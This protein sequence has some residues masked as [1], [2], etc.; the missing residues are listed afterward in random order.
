[1][2]IAFLKELSK[3][4]FSKNLEIRNYKN[5]KKYVKVIYRMTLM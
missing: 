2:N 1:M 5:N 3:M 4:S